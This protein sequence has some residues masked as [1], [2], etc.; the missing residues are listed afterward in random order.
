LVFACHDLI[1]KITKK[2]RSQRIFVVFV[3]E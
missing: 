3:P 1:T 2:Q